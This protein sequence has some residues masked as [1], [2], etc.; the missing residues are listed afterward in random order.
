M[1]DFISG[2]IESLDPASLALGAGVVASVFAARWLAA[3]FG[4]P[5]DHPVRQPTHGDPKV[6]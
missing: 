5:A 1:V 4:T 6:G 3:T 2:H